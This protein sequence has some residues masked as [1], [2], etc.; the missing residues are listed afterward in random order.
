MLQVNSP[1]RHQMAKWWKYLTLKISVSLQIVSWWKNV[2]SMQK[3]SSDNRF[4][5]LSY[6]NSMHKNMSMETSGRKTLPFLM[7]PVTSLTLTLPVGKGHTT[8]GGFNFMN[9]SGIQEHAKTCLCWRNTIAI[10]FVLSC[11]KFQDHVGPMRLY[12]SWPN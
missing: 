2:E 5:Q 3:L 11:K 12:L 9:V 1:L 7:V 6:T 8:P 10:P 4:A